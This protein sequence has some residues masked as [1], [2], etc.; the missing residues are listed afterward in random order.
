MIL[1]SRASVHRT[2]PVCWREV[3]T[4]A[5]TGRKGAAPARGFASS[6]FAVRDPAF[7]GCA[8]ASLKPMVSKVR[9]AWMTLPFQDVTTG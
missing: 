8:P 3:Q 4:F 6:S 5:V 2:R 9:S 7:A 1:S